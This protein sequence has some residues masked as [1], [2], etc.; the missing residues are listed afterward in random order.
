MSITS[1]FAKSFNN[2]T[3]NLN[4][5]NNNDF[6]SS[7][8]NSSFPKNIPPKAHSSNLQKTDQPPKRQNQLAGPPPSFSN[9]TPQ[10]QSQSQNNF[11]SNNNINDDDY[12]KIKQDFDTNI[13]QYNSSPEFISTTSYIFPK[14]FHSLSQIS[15]PMGIS[16]C[17]IKNT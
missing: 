5:N 10:T 8:Q 9:F 11:F 1:P 6:N 15:I 12:T 2:N 7:S 16:L 3:N 13:K 17:P 14:N 4:S